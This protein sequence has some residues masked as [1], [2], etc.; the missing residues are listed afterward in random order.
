MSS[1]HAG[2]E[3]AELVDVGCAD[4]DVWLVEG[5]AVGVAVLFGG[6]DAV[7]VVLVM[8]GQ[9]SFADEVLERA[10]DGVVQSLEAG[11]VDAGDQAVVV[12]EGEVARFEVDRRMFYF[13]EPAGEQVFIVSVRV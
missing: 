3:R 6:A 5:A 12:E 11:A 10:D 4:G 7:R 9:V 13:G 2:V 1:E 8:R